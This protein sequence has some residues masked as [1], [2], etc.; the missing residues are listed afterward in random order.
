MTQSIND[1]FLSNHTTSHARKGK[2][3]RRASGGTNNAVSVP[4][5]ALDIQK[6]NLSFRKFST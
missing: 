6:Q 1:I 4:R 5:L 3:S 2:I